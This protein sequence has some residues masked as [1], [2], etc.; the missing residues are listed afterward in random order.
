MRSDEFLLL[1]GSCSRQ[2]TIGYYSSL[3]RSNSAGKTLFSIHETHI[4]YDGFQTGVALKRIETYLGEDEVSEQVSSIKK[5]RAPHDGEDDSLAIE[6]GSFKWNEVPEK[7]EEN[8]KANGK[9][10]ATSKNHSPAASSAE[11]D[12]ATAVDTESVHSSSEDHKF[13]LKNISVRFPEG[14]LSVITGPTASGKTALLV[15]TARSFKSNV[16]VTRSFYR[17]HYWAR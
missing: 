11:T 4:R 1:Y 7:P 16:V 3:D 8:S 13:E 10:K 2:S 14:E 12:T 5:A 17:W 6:N 15:S 9:T